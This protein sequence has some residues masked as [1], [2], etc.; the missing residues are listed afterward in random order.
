MKKR[1]AAEWEPIKG[2]MIAWPVFLPKEYVVDLTINYHVYLCYATEDDKELAI[3]SIASWGGNVENI[4]FCQ[5]EQGF[6]APWVRDWGLHAIFNENGEMKLAGAEYQMTTPFVTYEEPEVMYDAWKNP[7][8]T[9]SYEREEDKAQPGIAK[10]MGLEFIKL[11]FALTGGNIMSDGYCKMMSMHVLKTENR[12]KGISDENFFQM[13]GEMTGMTEYS[14]FSNYANFGLQHIDC[15]LKMIDEETLLVSR[16]SINH[17]LHD[18]YE[19]LLEKE[20]KQ[21]RTRYGRSYKI[22]RIDIVPFNEGSDELTAYVNSII[23]DKTVY[24]P[25]YGILQDQIALQQWREAMPG[26]EIKGFTFEFAEQPEIK[27]LTE[28]ERTGWGTEDVIHCRTRAVWDDKMLYLSVRRLG[29][30]VLESSDKTV[31]VTIIDYSKM[32]LV[33]DSLELI[34]RINGGSWEKQPLNAT[35]DKELFISV[36]NGKKGDKIDY[37][38]C[39][40]SLSGKKETMPRV[41]PKGFYTVEI[42]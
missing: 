16:V 42:K 17:P 20:V 30:E 31:N 9:D 38:V 28:Y 23:L 8:T 24:V 29:E 5:G 11:P 1:L 35:K 12:A 6:D 36:L 13:V 2:V 25:L 21:A 15:Y 18:R 14:I 40:E 3:S 27:N 19:D 10:Q 32:G 37:Y 34:Y 22:H 33:E 39:A 41:A 26:Y 7:L 4:T